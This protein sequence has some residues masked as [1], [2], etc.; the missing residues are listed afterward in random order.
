M[1]LILQRE[2]D[3]LKKN[4]LGLSAI[5]EENFY[6]SVR[7]IE[8]GNTK[9]ASQIIDSDPEIDKMEVDLEEE[10]LKIL[11]LHQPV[12]VD[13]RFIIAVLKINASLERIGDLA[14][15]IARCTE[16]VHT[17]F[18]GKGKYDFVAMAERT[19]ASVKQSLDALVGLDPDL[20]RKVR[21]NDSEIDRMKHE[22]NG[23]IRE[24]LRSN[25]DNADN[26]ITLLSVSRYLERV[27]DHASKIAEDVIY[28]VEGEIVRHQG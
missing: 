19:R 9:L 10:C 3:K 28:L 22:T 18:V 17:A 4:I 5:V 27:A 13:L 24:D 25:P 1:S 14:V 12:A 16:S 20:A 8:E 15:K 26:L 6:R 23:R 7:A 21:E 2:I 11:A